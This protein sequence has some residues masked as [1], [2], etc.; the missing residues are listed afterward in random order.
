MSMP[1]PEHWGGVEQG[2]QE[3]TALMQRKIYTQAEETLLKL[4]EFASMEGK[5][6][7]ML[8]RCHQAQQQ[9]V[10]ALECFA[11]AAHCYQQQNVSACQP[12]SL[13]LAEVLRAQGQIAQA[14]TML[15]VLQA[16]QPDDVALHDIRKAWR[17]EAR[18]NL[19]GQGDIAC[20]S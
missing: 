9:H 3:A 7:H 1:L 19:V 14:E 6:W 11:Q 8:G 2:L 4:L 12:V 20:R 13:R 5:A 15:D 18:G 16:Q 17:A 10:K